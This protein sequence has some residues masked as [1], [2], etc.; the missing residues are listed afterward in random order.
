MHPFI[1]SLFVF[2]F[3]FLL[4]VAFLICLFSLFL[5]IQTNTRLAANTRVDF[6]QML[7][8]FGHFLFFAIRNMNKHCRFIRSS[9]IR[10]IQNKQAKLDKLHN[11]AF[12]QRS[13]RS[14][15]KCI[16]F[17]PCRLGVFDQHKLHL[18]LIVLFRSLLIVEDIVQLHQFDRHQ[19]VHSIIRHPIQRRLTFEV[20]IR[21]FQ[22]RLYH[23][24]TFLLIVAVTIRI[25]HLVHIDNRP[26]HQ[27]HA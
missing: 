25:H 10:F 7:P 9:H 27:N 5:C 4:F 18:L 8:Y 6:T 21:R 26:T 3:I 2:L 12:T 17:Q 15:C 22:C 14:L 16:R 13:H 11:I 1:H 24:H 19:I 23:R 20:R